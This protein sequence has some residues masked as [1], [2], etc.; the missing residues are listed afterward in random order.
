[1]TKRKPLSIADA[2]KQAG[3]EAGAA[4][5]LGITRNTLQYRRAREVVPV[6]ARAPT[7]T[8]VLSTPADTK[9]L[10]KELEGKLAVSQQLYAAVVD[11]RPPQKATLT[12]TGS[13]IR[14]AP[15]ERL[16]AK[17][18]LIPDP[19]IKPDAPVN[20]LVAAGE[21]AAEKQPDTIVVIG[22]AFDMSSLSSYDRGKLQFEG[23]R[24]RLDIDAGKAGL[25][26]LLGPIRRA[27][28]YKPRIVFT[29]GNHENRIERAVEENSWLD[30]MIG[31]HDMQLEAMG[32]EVYP[33]LQPVVID[34]IAYCHYFPRGANG[35]VGQTKRGAP[36]AKSQL[37]REG[38]SCIAGHQQGLDVHCQS[39]GGRL[40]WG[41]IAG[42]FYQH[43]EAYLSP[44][45]NEHWRGVIM[46]HEVAD[47]SFNP[48]VVS[49]NYLVSKYG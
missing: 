31:P 6:A 47:G 22:D 36:N 8:N 19:Q 41:V 24:Y 9:A 45:G 32:F 37:T 21:Y 7:T 27:K 29:K 15:R 14:R 13:R 48:M 28:G 49:L 11:N 12:H 39:L 25:E 20:H 40:Q 38:R 33:F 2:L 16:G 43:T 17:H 44:Q 42:S 10:I 23:R 26:A 35:T 46:L 1:M 3:T 34:G 4:R 18:L 5:L 30:G